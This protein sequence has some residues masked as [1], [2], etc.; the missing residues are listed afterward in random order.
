MTKRRRE[1]NPFEKHQLDI[2][3]STLNMPDPILGVMGGM[4][5]SEAR[6][7]IV[8]KT[9]RHTFHIYEDGKVKQILHKKKYKR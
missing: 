8:E 9:G 4:T 6:K 2:A 1:L 7:I 5:K 3:K